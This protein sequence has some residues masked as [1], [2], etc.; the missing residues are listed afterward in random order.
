MREMVRNKLDEFAEICAKTAKMNGNKWN[1][2]AKAY[3]KIA[4][5]SCSHS[6]LVLIA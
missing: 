3:A 6:P 1:K 5:D 4:K 2:S